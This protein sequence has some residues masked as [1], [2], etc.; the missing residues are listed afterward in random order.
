MSLVLLRFN[1][2]LRDDWDEFVTKRSINGS[3][4]HT[5]RFYDHNP[6]NQ[7][8]DHSYLVYKNKKI[9]SVI[10]FSI[11]E[12]AGHKVLHSHPRAT[13]GGFVISGDVNVKEAVSL[14]GQLIDDAKRSGINEIII[15]NPFRI[16]YDLHGD[17]MDY[18]M[19]YRG[20]SIKSRELEISIR[21]EPKDI[22]HSR[23]TKGTRSGV[24]KA[25][26]LLTVEESNDYQSFWMLLEKTLLEKYNVKPTHSFAEFCKLQASVG[27]DKIRL[28]VTRHDDKIVAGVLVFL[29][30]D[31]CVHAQYIAFDIL[32]QNMRPLNV[33]I[34][35]IAG[36]SHTAGYKYFNLGMANENNGRTI[37]YNLFSFK[38]SYGGRGVLRETMHLLL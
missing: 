33:L 6:D 7:K 25:Q 14:V 23:Y 18:A 8:D 28:F 38:E 16:L 26:K 3:F 31:I 2:A 10:A 32:Y 13:Y 37:N 19:W 5:R 1:D 9:I 12:T 27:D 24:H 30:N 22:L 17:E 34:D 20:F 15:R 4:L 11:T 36:W 21:L 29:V 35:H